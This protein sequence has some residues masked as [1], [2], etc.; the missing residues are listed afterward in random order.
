MPF[1]AAW[2]GKL[3]AATYPSVQRRVFRLLPNLA[4]T[5]KAT[6]STRACI[7]WYTNVR[8]WGRRPPAGL[9]NQST[10]GSTAKVLTS[11]ISSSH[12]S[13]H[14][15]SPA[16]PPAPSLPVFPPVL[17]LVRP[18]TVHVFYSYR[19]T[20]ITVSDGPEVS[21]ERDFFSLLSHAT[22]HDT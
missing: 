11:S 8:L 14:R 15:K 7:S 2:R 9:R 16:C 18:I 20:G 19:H 6:T 13:Q 10:R 17:S 3:R 12:S 21:L 1:N 4:L 5:N 22:L